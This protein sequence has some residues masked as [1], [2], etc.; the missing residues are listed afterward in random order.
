M[1]PRAQVTSVEAIERFR[2][3]LLVYLSAARAAV[4]EVSGDVART[5]QWIQ[6]DQHRH[7]DAEVTRRTRKV[8]QLRQ[9][10]FRE[11]L[12][13]SR[14]AP[15]FQQMELHR[16]ERALAEAEAK[17]ATTRKWS[18]D[19]ENRTD[20]LLKQVELLHGFLTVEMAKAAAHLGRIVHTLDAYLEQPGSPAPGSMGIEAPPGGTPPGG[21]NPGTA[22][23]GARAPDGPSPQPGPADDLRER[24]TNP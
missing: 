10:L 13:N 11:Q 14:G 5:R 4:D 18:R 16:A 17:R 20:P 23:D 22:S 3:A 2:V 9:E 24:S 19:F 15:S 6:H 7:W 21:G 1:N 12:S 8:E